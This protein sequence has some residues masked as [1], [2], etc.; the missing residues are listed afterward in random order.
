[1]IRWWLKTL[2]L[3][4]S[5]RSRP[6]SH[7][8][9]YESIASHSRMRVRKR[10]HFAFASE[11]NTRHVQGNSRGAQMQA[12]ICHF[13]FFFKFLYRI[14]ALIVSIPSVLSFRLR[15]CSDVAHCMYIAQAGVKVFVV[16]TTLRGQIGPRTTPGGGFA[17]HCTDGALWSESPL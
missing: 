16:A 17:D 1:M 11:V 6:V 15:V 8:G 13:F 4:G 10:A 7:S 14:A 2:K 9:S 5:N 3:K 12:G